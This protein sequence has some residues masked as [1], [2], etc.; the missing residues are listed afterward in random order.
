MS[1]FW[2]VKAKKTLLLVTIFVLFIALLASCSSGTDEGS[3]GSNKEEAST[4][5][6]KDRSEGENTDSSEE[7]ASSD[8]KDQDRGEDKA[9][10]EEVALASGSENRD[11][12]SGK[13]SNDKVAS[14][15]YPN[16]PPQPA[17]IPARGIPQA[18]HGWYHPDVDGDGAGS[19]YSAEYQ[20]DQQPPGW[21]SYN[22]V[23]WDN[24]PETPNPNQED[25]DN[26]GWG[27]FCDPEPF[28]PYNPNQA[29]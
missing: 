29:R 19:G 21:V 26:D 23:H 20:I 18:G 10:S 8:S 24:C 12:R 5:G 11:E 25:S 22:Y 27:D 6:S 16:P 15:N 14:P 1:R 28:I 4:S 7:A 17:F 9:S 3:K 13:G 2:L